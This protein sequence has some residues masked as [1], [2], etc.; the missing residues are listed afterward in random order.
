ML[1]HL[2]D[3]VMT[4]EINKRIVREFFANISNH[5]FD[6][7][8]DFID[9][10]VAWWSAGGENL[11]FSGTLSKSVFVSSMNA[12]GDIFSERPTLTPR[13]MVAE[14]DRVAVE[15]IGHA[16]TK[17]G[18]NY[19]NLYHIQLTF[20]NGKIVAAREYHDTLYAKIVLIDGKTSNS[21]V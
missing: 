1:L 18:R 3:N 15:L 11:V 6:I 14:G 20:K 8:F 19:D 12:M 9:D 10:D 5:N 7:A 17:D 4:I 16:V 21:P 13:S 2:E